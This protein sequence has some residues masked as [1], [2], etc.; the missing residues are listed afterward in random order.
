MLSHRI[1]IKEHADVTSLQRV[2]IKEQVDV[3]LLQRICISQHDD[4]M[5]SQRICI[6]EH[7]NVMAS[8]ADV[9]TKSYEI[10]FQPRVVV[11][12]FIKKE[13]EFNS[14]LKDVDRVMYGDRPILIT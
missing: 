1:C 2:C 8:A 13:R 10:S 3:T 12:L 7:G 5:L 9:G 14:V 11:S 6:K 4:V